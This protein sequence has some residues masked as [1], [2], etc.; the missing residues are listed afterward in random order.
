MVNDLL[1][2]QGLR[3]EWIIESPVGQ[4]I[5]TQIDADRLNF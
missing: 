2:R 1:L 3:A 4:A 5:V